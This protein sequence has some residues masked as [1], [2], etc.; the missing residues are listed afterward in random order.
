MLIGAACLAVTGWAAP[1]P[2]PPN[3]VPPRTAD[4]QPDIQGVWNNATLTPLERP[5]AMASKAFLTPAEAAA[6]EKVAVEQNNRDRGRLQSGV[7]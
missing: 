3:Y 4:G 5:A 6:F 1:P 2:K 7:V